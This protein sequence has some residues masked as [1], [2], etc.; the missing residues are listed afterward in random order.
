MR[1]L[2]IHTALDASA[3]LTLV[4]CDASGRSVRRLDLGTVAA[5]VQARDVDLSELRA[6]VYLATLRD[7]AGQ[8]SHT[9]RIVLR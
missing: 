4:L 6:G 7:A 8:H 2:R 3:S 9:D 5:G 1:I